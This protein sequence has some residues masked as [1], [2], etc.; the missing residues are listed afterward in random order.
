MLKAAIFQFDTGV[1][2][3]QKSL[4]NLLKNIDY[5][6]FEIDLYL[7][8]K[9]NFWNV[10]FPPEL[11]VI[12]V[13]P[14]PA[15]CKYLPFD[16]VLKHWPLEIDCRKEYDL[17][18][19]FN[20]YQPSCAI[21][22]LTVNAKRRVMWI[23]NNVK[24]KH[25]NEWKYRVL[26]TFFRGKFK[27]F[28]EFVPCSGALEEPFRELSGITDRSKKFPVIENYI[29]VEDIRRKA[30]IV[31]EDLIL[32]E[33]TV[34]FV[35]VGK[36]CSQ[37][38]YDIMLPSFADACRKGAAIRLYILG[39]GPDREALEKLS[40]EL[41]LD[42]KVFFLGNRQNP[43]SYMNIMDAYIST[44]RY[45]GQPLNT[46]EAKAIGLPLYCSK[47]LEQ[48]T[49]GLHGIENM[50]EALLHAKKE[51]K[52]PDDLAEYNARILARFRAL[53]EGEI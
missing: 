43:Y 2:G 21:G 20:S 25:G 47:N 52:R 34:N 26:W 24:I 30:E 32:D 44:S 35:A 18:V 1:G 15:I 11:N 7:N 41:G 16:F 49:E 39:D 42:N 38:G 33:E 53:A 14:L 23:H 28:D 45:E 36:L 3:I 37:K 46:M 9:S 8:E 48:Y 19:D 31:P 13:D 51:K 40:A 17:A 29:D 4:I 10:E 50:S 5:S 12:F 6:V 22:A 27:H